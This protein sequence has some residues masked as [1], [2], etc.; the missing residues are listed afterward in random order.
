MYLNIHVLDLI[1]CRSYLDF[2]SLACSEVS[3]SSLGHVI[4][5]ANT[6]QDYYSPDNVIG[7]MLFKT[8][9]AGQVPAC[10]RG[11]QLKERQCVSVAS[12]TTGYYLNVSGKLSRFMYLPVQ[13]QVSDGR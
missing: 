13:F 5:G 3:S 7:Q 12:D 4:V 11:E 1:I 10:A 6:V 2:D 9:N 8:H